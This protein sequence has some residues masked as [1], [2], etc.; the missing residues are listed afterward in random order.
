MMNSRQ[1]D[2]QET[3]NATKVMGWIEHLT[4]QPDFRI[5]LD[6]I[7]HI[8]RLT[9]HQ[10]DRD[11]WAGR[12]RSE[13]DWHQP[14]EWARRRALVAL[15]ERGL[16]VADEYTGE[17]LVQF[18]PDREVGPMVTDL[19][20]WINSAEAAASHPVIRAALFHQRFTAIHPFRDGNGRTAR[21]LTTLLLWR[22]GFP[23]K[24]LILQRVLDEKR[25]AYIAAL[26][27]ADQGNVQGWVQFFSEAV[28]DALQAEAY[29]GS[30]T[31]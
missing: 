11:Y 6:L 17:L 10:T 13:V 18:P 28:A 19:L 8:N 3:R 2:E 4:R 29:P 21:A 1:R 22:A 31:N 25:D 27:M 26:R 24:I 5:D 20:A 30:E 9:L 23:A 15:D 12:I 16:G 7:C 14:E